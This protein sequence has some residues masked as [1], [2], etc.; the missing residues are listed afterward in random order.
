MDDL[1]HKVLLIKR[2]S[3]VSRAELQKQLAES[4]GR[5]AKLHEQQGKKQQTFLRALASHPRAR[6]LATGFQAWR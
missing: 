5:L 1:N 2:A 3:Q 4:H 6:S